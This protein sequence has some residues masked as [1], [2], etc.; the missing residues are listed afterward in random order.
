MPASSTAIPAGPRDSGTTR[1]VI[2]TE[3]TLTGRFTKKIHRS[4]A[5]R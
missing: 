5:P 4:P 1:G 2:R 3:A